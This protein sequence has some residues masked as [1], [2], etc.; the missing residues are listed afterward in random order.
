M[1]T[2]RDCVALAEAIF[3][4]TNKKV[5]SHTLRR[6]FGLVAFDGQFRKS[7]LDTLANYAGY[8]SCDDFLD[9]LKQEEDLVELLV[10]LQVQNVEIDEYYIN[11]LIERDISM[12]AIMMAGHLINMRLEQNDQERIIRLFQALEPV[13][14]ERHRYHAIVSV[15]A[16]YVGP[17]FHALEDEGFMVRLMKETPLIDLVLAFYVPVME[18]DAGYGR[19]IEMMLG[20][21]DDSEHQAFGH[22]LLAT[23]ALLE[24][25]RE[26]AHNQFNAIPAG[27]YFPHSGRTNCRIGLPLKRCKRGRDPKP[28]C[29]SRERRDFLFQSHHPVTRRFRPSRFVGTFH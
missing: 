24:N 7:T 22:S 15:F 11:R 4:K 6:F 16:H 25:Q 14:R 26:Q 8:A 2:Q 12:E 9:R 1:Q 3:E 13:S 5:A 29:P 18:L 27:T 19:L 17:K 20:T 23:R 28:F 21:S 10:R